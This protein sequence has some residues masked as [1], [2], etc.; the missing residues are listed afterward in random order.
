MWS[1]V[2]KA[3]LF[4]C[5]SQSFPTTPIP[6][7]SNSLTF[8][9]YSYTVYRS[10]LIILDGEK[11]R[12]LKDQLVTQIISEFNFKAQ[13]HH[14][15]YPTSIKWLNLGKICSRNHYTNRGV[16]IDWVSLTESSIKVMVNIST[17]TTIIRT[18]M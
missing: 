10:V 4:F 14:Y 9:L 7:C 1:F 15:T 8:W 16:G 2:G 11:Q 6:S 5:V 17:I 13:L 18:L 12:F 3:V